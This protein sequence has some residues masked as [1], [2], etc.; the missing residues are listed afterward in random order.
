MNIEQLLAMTQRAIVDDA[1]LALLSHRRL[2]AR[3]RAQRS[4]DNACRL[5]ELTTVLSDADDEWA[6]N[7]PSANRQAPTLCSVPL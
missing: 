6:S 7:V 1:A 3:F 4:T 5:A 2:S